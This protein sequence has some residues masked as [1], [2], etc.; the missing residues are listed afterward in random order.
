MD[1]RKVFCEECRNDIE[2]SVTNKQMEGTIK[3]EIYTYILIWVK[4]PIAL[5]VVLRFM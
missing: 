5:T 4:L 1:E 3:G 2:F